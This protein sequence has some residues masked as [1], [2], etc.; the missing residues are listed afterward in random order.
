[1]SDIPERF[2]NNSKFSLIVL[3]SIG[4]KT[5]ESNIVVDDPFEFNHLDFIPSA[6][7]FHLEDFIKLTS[8]VLEHAQQDVIEGERIKLVQESNPDKIHEH[9]ETVITYKIK[10]RAPAKMSR[11]G[12]SRPQRGRSN[13]HNFRSAHD[14]NSTFIVEARPI[15]H[16]IE[17][18]IWSKSSTLA[19][20]KV[21]WLERTL[22]RYTHVFQKQ[23]ASKFYWDERLSDVFWQPQKQPLHQRPLVFFLRL[24][25][26]YVLSTPNVQHFNFNF[27]LKDN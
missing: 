27:S 4:E 21:L 10:S 17:F 15:D 16:Q 23:G 8:E 22:I 25:E 14:P 13:V 20:S 5:F 19:D 12:K 7:K 3:N 1:M 2:Q 26:H 18:S 11:D 9:G 24:H 6:G